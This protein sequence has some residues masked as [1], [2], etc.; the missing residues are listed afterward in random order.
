ME[1]LPSVLRFEQLVQEPIVD[2][3]E[4]HAVLGALLAEDAP[5][6]YYEF[7]DDIL[8]G[9]L[10]PFTRELM[11]KDQTSIIHPMDKELLLDEGEAYDTPL[12]TLLDRW[13]AKGAA[14]VEKIL[15]EKRRVLSR[16]MVL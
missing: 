10:D 2:T 4:F 1:K 5:L 15:E 12:E 14:I 7:M 6:E 8:Q 3:R 11:A 9:G 13:P 16:R